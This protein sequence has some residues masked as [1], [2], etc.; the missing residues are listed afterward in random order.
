[1]APA[2]GEPVCGTVPCISEQH[3]TCSHP[4]PAVFWGLQGSIGF[5][6]AGAA[7][8]AADFRQGPRH[9]ADAQFAGHLEL[10]GQPS[11]AGASVPPG[12]PGPPSPAAGRRCSG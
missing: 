1:M 7:L 2:G 6:I 3:P 5:L 11:C 10:L 9:N 4:G 8:Y 12:S